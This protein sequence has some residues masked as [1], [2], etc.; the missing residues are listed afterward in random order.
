MPLQSLS[1][2]R[3]L[4]PTLTNP[5]T[6]LIVR[7]LLCADGRRLAV[8]SAAN[9]HITH[10]NNVDTRRNLR[11]LILEYARKSNYQKAIRNWPFLLLLSSSV[12]RQQIVAFLQKDTQ[13]KKLRTIGMLPRTGQACRYDGPTR[14]PKAL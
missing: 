13:E 3:V 7:S 6:N 1:I 9:V 8:C 2:L 10:Y 4:C 12:Y 5:K 14:R 11:A